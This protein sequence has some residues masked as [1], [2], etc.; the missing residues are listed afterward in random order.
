MLGDLGRHLDEE[1]PAALAA[2]RERLAEAIRGGRSRGGRRSRRRLAWSG[3]SRPILGLAALGTAA[4]IGIPV[5]LISGGS[6][7][8]V[9]STATGG[10][11]VTVAGSGPAI[12]SD[13]APR[14]DQFVYVETRQQ[15]ESCR[16]VT[17]ECRLDPASM[18]RVW[19][20]A[21]GTRDGRIEQK[22]AGRPMSATVPGCRN[23]K[24]TQLLPEKKAAG[25]PGGPM[26]RV[27]ESC[28]P[29]PADHSG[30]PKD[31]T[32]MRN[33]LYDQSDGGRS[34]EELMF[35][36]VGEVARESYVPA[37]VR[38]ALFTAASRIPGVTRDP[39]AVDPGGRRAV[40]L[41]FTSPYDG[42]RR[43]YFFDPASYQ[44]LGTRAVATKDV[45]GSGTKKGE[46]TGS[47]AVWRLV[48]VDRA[49][50]LPD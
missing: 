36:A 46:V 30:L 2:Q 42:V 32:G 6:G 15:Y 23:G 38:K 22:T 14:P 33:H 44:Y 37:K 11:A 13:T 7:S 31:P 19:L 21:D 10:P 47:A 43:E 35:K 28:T 17:S 9:Q 3:G 50:Q 34:R 45:P 26:V 16:V 12:Q 29:H 41:A 49:G 39:K 20:S 40:R 5:M 27:T 1:P 8:S 25:R 4:A 24:Q 18:R 48:V